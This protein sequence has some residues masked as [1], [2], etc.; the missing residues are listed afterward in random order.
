[1]NSSNAKLELEALWAAVFH[2]PPAIDADADLLARMIVRCLPPSPPYG[3]AL[4]GVE[5][6]PD[7]AAAPA[8][9]PDQAEPMR[10]R[11]I[12][13]DTSGTQK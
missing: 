2:E 7:A 3:E 5:H 12:R 13:S 9:A 11:W 6:P 4:P 8:E 10:A 1:M